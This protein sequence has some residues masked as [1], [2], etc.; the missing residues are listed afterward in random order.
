MPDSGR[1]SRSADSPLVV[2]QLAY[3]TQ[4][5]LVPWKCLSLDPAD[6]DAGRGPAPIA[7][8]SRSRAFFGEL[9]RRAGP[10]CLED[11]ESAVLW[12]VTIPRWRRGGDA[13]WEFP[14]TLVAKLAVE[15]LYR[16]DQ[17]RGWSKRS[18]ADAAIPAT[19]IQTWPQTMSGPA[20]S[21]AARA[22]LPRCR[23]FPCLMMI[24][25]TPYPT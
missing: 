16:G 20:V 7:Y 6:S 9:F 10:P 3:V 5:R 1:V 12:V 18:R 13:G 17:V 15:R 24:L 25:P 8:A 4:D 21:A 22:P 11:G 2:H 23:F 19:C 14:A